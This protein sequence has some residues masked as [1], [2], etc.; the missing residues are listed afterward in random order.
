MH[1]GKP[2]RAVL[3][4]VCLL[5]FLISEVSA[6]DLSHISVDPS[7]FLTPYTPVNISGLVNLPAAPE[8]CFLRKITWDLTTNLINPEWTWT[9][10]LDGVEKS[11]NSVQGHEL[12]IS[13]SE[14]SYPWTV[15]ESIKFNLEGVSPAVDQ[16]QD[17][18]LLQ[19]QEWDVRGILVPNSTTEYNTLI[20]NPTGCCSSPVLKQS[21]GLQ[22]SDPILM[23]TRH[24]TSIPRRRRQ[25][26]MKHSRISLPH[27]HDL[28]RNTPMH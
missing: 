24:G 15:K 10:I 14:L 11:D 7:G 22:P 21:V 17:K 12:D 6:Y 18:T 1:G 4:A 27:V 26:T 3:L 16:T 8:I 9:L 2:G 13:S 20:V 5:V 23:K 25:N 28:K 19:I